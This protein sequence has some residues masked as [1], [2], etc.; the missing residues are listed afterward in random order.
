MTRFS[1]QFIKI[2]QLYIVV[3][4]IVKHKAVVGVLDKRWSQVVPSLY[5]LQSRLEKLGVT[6]VNGEVSYSEGETPHV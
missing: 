5:L 2:G 6:Y 1:L 4:K 3:S